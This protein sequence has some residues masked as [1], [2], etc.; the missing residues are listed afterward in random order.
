MAFLDKF[1]SHE[2]RRKK[3][4]ARVA[5]G[6]LKEFL[7]V[8]FP[9]PDTRIS[10]TKMLAV[11]FET[12]GLDPLNDKLLSIGSIALEEMKI[13]LNTA[14]HQLIRT[15]EALKAENVI[16]HQITDD[17]KDAG[18][19]LTEVVEDLLIQLQGKVMI[20]HFH[21]IEEDFLNQACKI[22]YGSPIVFPIVDTLLLQ[23]RHWDQRLVPYDPS[24]LR[25][26][27]LRDHYALPHH[28]AHNA[29]T[30]ALATGELLLA[31]LAE[32]K[33]TELKEVICN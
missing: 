29:L 18:N 15:D 23:K 21:R 19:A 14:Y 17:A 8:P 27:N 6:P 2:A 16:I 24:Q 9:P 7:S 26:S 20:A 1:R 25:L 28:K 12:T 5:D 22:L 31:Q 13:P 30:D 10:E 11:D 4:L 32:Y 3:L 33:H